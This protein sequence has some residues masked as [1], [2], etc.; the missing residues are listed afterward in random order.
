MHR[1]LL[2]YLVFSVAILECGTN[3]MAVPD[4]EI[5]S[6]NYPSD[7]PK[8]WDCTSIIRLPSGFT[9]LITLSFLAFNTEAYGDYLD[10]RDG[11]RSSAPLIGNYRGST[12]PAPIA[13]ASGRVWIK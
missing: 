6:P 7:Y 9:G 2:H 10:I 13:A 4:G 5:R 11:S 1:I 3:G 12:I 8:N